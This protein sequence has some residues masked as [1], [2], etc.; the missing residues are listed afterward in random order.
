MARAHV[1][2]LTNPTA[3]GNRIALISGELSPKL[4]IDAIRKHFPELVQR[5]PVGELDCVFPEG[6]RR[7][8]WDTS[9]SLKILGGAEWKCIGLEQSVVD[10]VTCLLELEKKWNI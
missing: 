3:A 2:V 9:R 1:N 6:A 7:T 5:T 10:T 8:K 4:V